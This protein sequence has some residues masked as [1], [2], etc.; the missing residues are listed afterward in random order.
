MAIIKSL[1]AGSSDSGRHPSE[2][3]AEYQVV[4][5][6]AG[7]LFQLSTFGSASRKSGPKVSQTIQFDQEMAVEI[8][9]AMRATFPKLDYV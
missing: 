1:S 7:I 9:R 4:V 8:F 3:E 6:D 5:D 2:V